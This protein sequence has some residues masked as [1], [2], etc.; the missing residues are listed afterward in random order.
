M[1]AGFLALLPPPAGAV[2][3]TDDGY[4]DRDVTAAAY[5]WLGP[6]TPNDSY[7]ITLVRGRS[8]RSVLRLLAPRRDL[9]SPAWA[10]N[11]RLTRIH[12]SKDWFFAE[13]PTYVL[14]RA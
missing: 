2:P 14:P 3:D 4:G 11:E 8:V 6:D 1:L 12:V 7:A 9:F 13:H 5:D 10:L